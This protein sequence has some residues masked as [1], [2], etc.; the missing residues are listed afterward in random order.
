MIEWGFCIPS[1]HT[2]ATGPNLRLRREKKEKEEEKKRSRLVKTLFL[3]E[4][5]NENK[6]QECFN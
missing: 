6:L 4:D 2:G 1:V 3:C 5:R